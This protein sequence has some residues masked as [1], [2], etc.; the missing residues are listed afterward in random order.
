MQAPYDVP[1]STT[2][3][4]TQTPI[5]EVHLTSRLAGMCQKL[6]RLLLAL[7]QRFNGWADRLATTDDPLRALPPCREDVWC[8]F[9]SMSPATRQIVCRQQR[10]ARALL[11]VAHLLKH[12]PDE[13]TLLD[14]T[15][16]VPDWAVLHKQF[17]AYLLRRLVT[18]RHLGRQPE[19]DFGRVHQWLQRRN[20]SLTALPMRWPVAVDAAEWGVGEDAAR[21]LQEQPMEAGEHRR[22]EAVMA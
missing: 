22:R 10:D 12:L 20:R 15:Q 21:L 16:R 1:A 13:A 3:A 2:L 17:S 9:T 14:F 8:W 4:Q 7:G 18:L 6:R 11:R 5:A 19:K